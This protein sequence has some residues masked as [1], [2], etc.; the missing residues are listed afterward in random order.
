MSKEVSVV[1]V[2]RNRP[3]LA[4]QAVAS[5]LACD[6]EN[7]EVVVVDQG[8]VPLELSADPR[9]RLLRSEPGL[10]R[11]RNQG[12]SSARF[13]RIGCT[14]DD[15]VAP[16]DWVTRIAEVLEPDRAG[17]VFGNVCAG[18][19]GD[20][21]IPAHINQQASSARTPWQRNR[22]EGMG[23]C[24]ALRR[25]AWVE[26]GGFDEYLGTGAPLPAGDE[27]D[28]AIRALVAGWEVRTDPRLELVH[29]GE[30]QRDELADLTSSYWRGT[31]AVFAKFLRLRPGP[32]LFSL[33]GLGLRWL[34]GGGSHVARS[35]EAARLAR[36]TSF[37]HGFR[38]GFTTPL[39]EGCFSAPDGLQRRVAPPGGE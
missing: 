6:H 34:Y 9:L 33:T 14:D 27:T 15:C 10:C 13:D 29:L 39:Q 31:G 3:V 23:A 26:L 8:D 21:L 28:F 19:A 4:I 22:I 12:I 24:M 25:S 11:G 2:T 38:L 16:R 30:R 7:F 20:G 5:I 36:L 35:T 1:I 17:L 37:L 18:E 32:A